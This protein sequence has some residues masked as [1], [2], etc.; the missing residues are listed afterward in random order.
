GQLCESLKDY[1]GAFVS[2]E[3][4]L[5][6]NE[7]QKDVILKVCE[8][9]LRTK[10]D[11]EK[12]KYWIEKAESVAQ[13]SEVVFH[14]K[15]KLIDTESDGN[16]TEME[17][18]LKSELVKKPSNV[19]VRIKLLKLYV[20]SKR[21]ETAISHAVSVDS[22]YIFDFN[23]DWYNYLVHFYSLP[24]VCDYLHHHPT[25]VATHT[26]KVFAQC[27]QLLLWFPLKEVS[28]VVEALH[29]FDQ[30]LV[31]VSSLQFHQPQW[32]AFLSEMQGY[33][34]F[35]CGCLLFKRALQGQS[36]WKEIES[37]ATLCFLASDSYR[38]ID[39][40]SD[41]YLQGDPANRH[42]IKYLH[43]M[44]CYRLSQ[45]GHVL[46]EVVKRH[47]SSWSYDIT[48]RCCTPQVRQQ[49]HSLVFTFPGMRRGR[50][51]SFLL[52]EGA[53]NNVSST[54]PTKPELVEYD[55]VSVLLNSTDLNSIIWLCLHYYNAAKDK[56]QPS[57]K[58]SLFDNLPYSSH[59]LSS[60]ANLGVES[61]SQLD[62]E[63]FLYAAVYCAGRVMQQQR[64][65][66]ARPHILP[67]ILC[68]NF[69]T[70]EQA[71]W[72]SLAC[73][74]RE[75]MEFDNFTKHRLTL[76]RG[77]DTVRLSEGHGMSASIILHIAH[78][79]Q[80]QASQMKSQLKT[81]KDFY[82]KLESVEDRAAHFWQKALP[83][84]QRLQNN[85]VLKMPKVRLFPDDS[86][87]DLDANRMRDLIGDCEYHLALTFMSK[88]DHE[89]AIK[90][91]ESLATPWASYHTAQVYRKL[92]SDEKDAAATSNSSRRQGLGGDDDDGA[93]PER[94]EGRYVAL[95][96]KVKEALCLTLD[97]LQGDKTHEL[98]HVIH[99]ELDDIEF[100]LTRLA[101]NNGPF[102][103]LDDNSSTES[104][105]SAT[106]LSTGVPAAAAA[107]T[108]SSP[109]P[110]SEPPLH[111]SS[112]LQYHCDTSV[113][114]DSTNTT[115]AN[116]TT[117]PGGRKQASSTPPPASASSSSSKKQTPKSHRN[118]SESNN[119][120]SSG[121]H[122]RPSPER[123]DAQLRAL[124]LS[125]MS[126]LKPIVDQNKELTRF[127][128]SLQNQLKEAK[129]MMQLYLTELTQ[130]RVMAAATGG[131]GFPAPQPPQVA[132]VPPPPHTPMA[133]ATPCG[134]VS[135]AT[136]H[137]A[138]QPAT[139]FGPA[140]GSP[141]MT[142]ATHQMPGVATG[143]QHHP[144]FAY[145]QQQQQQQHP[146]SP[147][148]KA[149][150]AAMMMM[151]SGGVQASPANPPQP[152][153]FGAAGP[154]AP[155]APSVAVFGLPPSVGAAAA[156][157]SV[158][159][160]FG[161]THG[162]PAAGAP[163]AF[164][165]SHP[166][167][168]GAT[169]PA[170]GLVIR[171][172]KSGGVVFED[173][174]RPG[175]GVARVKEVVEDDEDEEEAARVVEDEEDVTKHE[176]EEE[177]EEEIEEEEEE[178]VEDPCHVDGEYYEE[179]EE[180]DEEDEEDDE[181][182]VDDDDEVGVKGR[183][184]GSNA[185][186]NRR[187]AVPAS[188]FGSSTPSGG[189][190][191]A[192]T[193][194][195]PATFQIP[196]SQLVQ[197]WPFGHQTG[198]VG[199][200]TVTYSPHHHHHQQHHY[201]YPHHQQQQPG[202]GSP[203]PL[204][205]ASSSTVFPT[206][207]ALPRPGYFADALRGHSLQYGQ[208]F[209]VASPGAPA[210]LQTPPTTQPS[211]TLR[212]ST[213]AS[214]S[215]APA[216]GLA[217]SSP[218]VSPFGMSRL[219]SALG[220]GQ[221]GVP[222]AATPPSLGA[223][224]TLPA[225]AGSPAGQQL[226]SSTL[227]KVLN[228]STSPHHHQ[229]SPTADPVKGSVASSPADSG[230]K[231]PTQTFGG[232]TFTCTPKVDTTT[233]TP[234][235][236]KPA[237]SAA[238]A[239]TTAQAV[240][241]AATTATTTTGGSGGAKPFWNFS[242]A[243]AMS[244]MSTASFL[245]T[246]TTTATTT[247]ANATTTTASTTAP[248]T[249]FGNMSV[250]NLFGGSPALSASACS[251]SSPLVSR[252][253]FSPASTATGATTTTTTSA[254]TTA[255]PAAT[256]PFSGAGP[257]GVPGTPA[258]SFGGFGG[259]MGSVSPCDAA[260]TAASG[261]NTNPNTGISTS[262][263]A[264]ATPKAA[265]A[266]GAGGAGATLGSPGAAGDDEV[267]EYEPNVNFVPVVPLPELVDLKTGEE[268]EE[269]L[270]GDR[271]K[272]YRFDAET[273][274]WKERGVGELKILHN[275][276]T[277]RCRVLM[278]RE[279]V[280]K[281]CANHFLSADIKLKT[282]TAKSVCWS[283]QDFAEEELKVETF[284][285]RFKTADV[286]DEFR[287]AFEKAREYCKLVKVQPSSQQQQQL[288]SP[289][290]RDA[291]LK[292]GGREEEAQH[293]SPVATT[294]TPFSTP[295][296][297]TPTN[298]AAATT[299]TNTTTGT[300]TTTKPP[301]SELFK[302]AEGSWECGVCCVVNKGGVS[303]CVACQS[304][305]PA[306]ISKPAGGS[307]SGPGSATKL[308][309]ASSAS[310][311]SLSG[312]AAGGKAPP[313]SEL[314]KGKSGSWECPGCYLMNEGSFLRCPACNTVKPGVDK[315]DLGPSGSPASS[316][317]S[318]SSVFPPPI[319]GSITSSGFKFVPDTPTT[320]TA[321]SV[322]ASPI[323]SSSSGV[324]G[325]KLGDI[326]NG[327]GASG[328]EGFK[329]GVSNVNI[330]G[331]TIGGSSSSGANSTGSGSVFGPGGFTLGGS[332]VGRIGTG[333][334]GGSLSSK[335]SL[336]FTVPVLSPTLTTPTPFLSSPS[337]S[338][339]AAPSGTPSASSASK[340]SPLFQM[341]PSSSISPSS[342]ALSS[343]SS[344]S[345]VIA[346][347]ATM[348]ASSGGIIGSAALPA[349]PF[350]FTSVETSNIF[351][352]ASG[353]SKTSTNA[354]SSSSSSESVGGGGGGGST[355]GWCMGPSP[356]QSGG[357]VP[358][359]ELFKMQVGEWTCSGCYL[360]CQ[361]TQ[362]K[363]AACGT[364]KPNVAGSNAATT[365]TNTTTSSSSAAIT[366]T[367]ATTSVPASASAPAFSMGNKNCNFV[368]GSTSFGS[369][370]FGSP[371][372]NTTPFDTKTAGGLKPSLNWGTS[373]TTANA[374]TTATTTTT[375][376][377]APSFS[378]GLGGTKPA[379]APSPFNISQ[380]KFNFAM[381]T[382]A[383]T[384]T[385]TP[386][387]QGIL[388]A[389]PTTSALGDP[390][391]STTTGALP[392][393]PQP[394]FFSF[395]LNPSTVTAPGGGGVGGSS[396]FPS[397]T[398]TPLGGIFSAAPSASPFTAA[399]VKAPGGG[400]ATPLPAPIGSP[401]PPTSTL[402][403][404]LSTPTAGA[405][406]VTT[407]SKSPT[408]TTN[409]D[410]GYYVNRD[411]E[412]SHIT[413][414]PVMPLPDKVEVRTGE[415][416]ETCL[417][418]HRAKLY[419]FDG[420][421]WKERGLGNIK[422]LENTATQR[423]RLV[424]RREQVLKVCC[425][426]YITAELDLKPKANS[427]GCAWVWCAFDSSDGGP[428]AEL[429]KL[430]IRFKTADIANDFKEVFE[431]AKQKSAAYQASSAS[432]STSVG[433][434]GGQTPSDTQ[435]GTPAASVS[436]VS[437]A[438]SAAST[439]E[440][441]DDVVFV[442]Q[443]EATPEQVARARSLLLPDH[444]YLYETRQPC[445]GCRGCDPR[446][447]KSPPRHSYASK[448]S[449][450]QSDLPK[451]SQTQSPAISSSS[452]S[453]ID[454]TTT[455]TAATTTTTSVFSSYAKAAATTTT[456]TNDN[457][458]T[459]TP[460]GPF[461]SHLFNNSDSGSNT[462]FSTLAAQA[463]SMETPAFQRDKSKPF[464][465]QGAGQK[466]FGS[467]QS[468]SSAHRGGDD[469]D[470]DEEVV[471]NDDIHFEPIIDLPALVDRKSGEEDESPLFVQRS[472]L[473]RFDTDLNCWKEKGIGNMKILSHN[474]SV[475][476]RL[477]FRREQ[478]LKVAC[479]HLLTSTLALNRMSTSE[480][481]WCW[482][483]KDYSDDSNGMV[484]KFAIRFKSI[485]LATSFQQCFLE[486]QQKLRLEESGQNVSDCPGVQG[487]SATL[488]TLNVEPT[489]TP[490]VTPAA[491][492]GEVV[493]EEEEE[494]VR[495]EKMASL[496]YKVDKDWVL[497]DL[498]TVQVVSMSTHGAYRVRVTNS[499]EVVLCSHIITRD[500]NFTQC[501]GKQ[502]HAGTWTAVDEVCGQ[503][504]TFRLNFSSAPAF[505]QCKDIFLQGKN[506]AKQLNLTEQSLQS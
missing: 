71:E 403:L 158:A 483:A 2:Y 260:A 348:S 70:A 456:T 422:I 225:S 277:D 137:Q 424:M 269:K 455:T 141:W 411:G 123:I 418:E 342:S 154:G 498:G 283:A 44:G 445:P 381:A 404:N 482:V 24:S 54:V 477:L 496:Y 480:T 488:S 473:Y 28:D 62:T 76:M 40:R 430:S 183:V 61:L 4:C 321:S 150:A 204:Q 421:E 7:N 478:V 499:S 493:V 476:F 279:Q 428:E 37:A 356:Q 122:S 437:T 108:F 223:S 5:Q 254:A 352:N 320:T 218:A 102:M 406:A 489:V 95:L 402:T 335:T 474:T 100:Q 84:V 242:F 252:S 93:S 282:T 360:S 180:E 211:G 75:K 212:A 210:R 203:P 409:D 472:K 241:A 155:H 56:A 336:P 338:V 385:S 469:D 168:Q 495:F 341:S 209:G 506:I 466:L 355:T 227:L 205:S 29:T 178:E 358:L 82:N 343:S 359:S 318:S 135:G 423:L 490:S 31:H 181:D 230:L 264:A 88:G 66:P 101:I 457:T 485:E 412:D 328:A 60:S 197:Q 399:S 384:T 116:T 366:T 306:S 13:G 268:G 261:T 330:G 327:L 8:L 394:P 391:P 94:H 413:F 304:A 145:L 427:K 113:L 134:G 175:G 79:L 202:S 59:F 291:L 73:K 420:G 353:S 92:A 153:L 370:T 224:G 106:N 250:G 47:S 286:A 287:S 400:A 332:N 267:E 298:A 231:G 207:P 438:T 415:E 258:G 45:A 117:P 297:G 208:G 389:G 160:P 190:P 172:K 307:S 173:R 416:D 206:T 36:S 192:T 174:R 388:G 69:C 312:V 373:T 23:V 132:S 467:K 447:V 459:T 146:A 80:N 379:A 449:S 450:S 481:S 110:L 78:T 129:E 322:T 83:L 1:K 479:N 125:H 362:S 386:G 337:S 299:T 471:S 143:P 382:P 237:Q 376:M 171:G 112:P 442:R 245:G 315:K 246:N 407:P 217:G 390:N 440:D 32:T 96:T 142:P 431:T 285:A 243:D 497:L 235:Q 276:A 200:S 380:P 452:C 11:K 247:A 18:F 436:Q 345:S 377:T 347:P 51:S 185:G 49:L 188:P 432:P 166:H 167:H 91:F 221:P 236:E 232:F 383:T 408:A 425:N 64:Q 468:P 460:V 196:D 344:S 162:H 42:F 309:P 103:L 501:S 288:Q 57:Y 184:G 90:R 454:T 484:E 284:A 199:K 136:L 182:E 443:E 107:A 52:S 448:A 156:A 262:T 63:V 148:T 494:D 216:S 128:V 12:V 151:A 274:Q 429:Q 405:A 34:F 313:L 140:G 491:E 239:M 398:P 378:F 270:F 475:R 433:L 326:S 354:T 278:R 503:Q 119:D 120:V 9:L 266:A 98:N 67:K 15:E 193:T 14:L 240:A 401:A 215:T 191:T 164:P 244:K 201:H 89:G 222:L 329:F 33:F 152:F 361:A 253:L 331:S 316:S 234:G 439:T 308:T 20:D 179:E 149:A 248:K 111:A 68:R 195:S 55:Q 504:R 387:G 275:R 97:R 255:A 300:T 434:T 38:P 124:Q 186:F 17:N 393:P 351:G 48:V 39:K 10:V 500:T 43:K 22:L 214:G 302:K 130:Y 465:W 144:S 226:P 301:L 3:K 259:F 198:L 147:Y 333:T 6:F 72:W 176:E 238:V 368:F 363:C 293:A 502:K 81:G 127:N 16:P 109:P 417:F 21:I 292:G 372:F 311:S 104:F 27:K 228:S 487:L 87:G 169:S 58:F 256:Q 451:A 233:K 464:S 115:A 435:R 349:R 458:T 219:A 35:F 121:G 165:I 462:L 492:E 310:A 396:G 453:A 26:H 334:G 131:I 295:T 414:D 273:S 25:D 350:V 161:P 99:N 367:A 263:L 53:F 280:L 325:F 470:D 77:L 257:M 339:P 303:R 446:D 319:P 41:L 139:S 213:P 410:D 441:D 271:A 323:A 86:D 50:E 371:G 159:S 486:C 170:A 19:H 375:M 374:T 189:A 177:E 251:S 340:G 46:C 397:S 163:S 105:C 289:S 114:H 314:F 426:H 157:A 357:T 444:F 317:S 369:A 194:A 229:P 461:S 305:A 324:A 126:I 272:L 294:T 85:L 392:Q 220:Q 249:P 364:P 65:E 118:T 187:G 505:S 365:N 138:Q 281:L 419:R 265:T 74:F 395:S 463:N 290:K 30:L 296:G 133:G 346:P